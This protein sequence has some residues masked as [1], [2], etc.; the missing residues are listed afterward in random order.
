M[1]KKESGKRPTKLSKE[2]GGQTAPFSAGKPDGALE[3][4]TA[5][6]VLGTGKSFEGRLTLTERS[7]F[8][9]GR[10]PPPDFMKQFEE[11]EPGSANRIIQLAENQQSH[12]HSLE[13]TAVDS[14]V[15]NEG[16]G[17]IFAFILSMVTILGGIGLIAIGKSIEGL[18]ALIGILV[19]LTAVFIV[20]KLG[21]IA[22]LKNK[23]EKVKSN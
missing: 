12:R 22:A 17:Q 5:A 14:N 13:Q 2:K 10:L 3:S 19:S 15:R 9:S 20:G 8:Y 6:D 21:G 7:E 11:I 1:S 16:R 18:I 4:F 23:E